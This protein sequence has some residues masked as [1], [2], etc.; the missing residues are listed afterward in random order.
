MS[1]LLYIHLSHCF[2]HS[3][4]RC[5]LPQ[6]YSAIPYCWILHYH[7]QCCSGHPVHLPFRICVSIY[8]DYVF[9][10]GTAVSKGI[11]ILNVITSVIL[12]FIMAVLFTLLLALHG[13]FHISTSSPTLSIP[14]HPKMCHF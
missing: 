4:S 3:I 14:C 13:G 1:L 8:L 5:S 2:L 9:K 12:L 11:H 6:F 7:K 10:S